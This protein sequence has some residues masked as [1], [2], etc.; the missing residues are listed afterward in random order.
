MGRILMNI[1]KLSDRGVFAFL[2]LYGLLIRL[3]FF[4]RDYVDRDE[5]SFIIMGQSVVDGHLPYTQLWDI[6]PPVIFFFFALIIYVFGKSFIAIR[7][8]GVALVAITAFFTY[9]LTNINNAKRIALCFGALCVILQSLF[10]SLQ[11]VMSEHIAMAFFT[12]AIYFMAKTKTKASTWLLCGVLVGLGLMV[13]L[14]LAYVALFL[15]CTILTLDFI[16]IRS[17]KSLSSSMLFGI[18]VLIVIVACFLPY[19][20]TDNSS[21][22]WKSVVEAPLAYAGARQYSPFKLLMYLM[23]CLLLFW[24]GFKKGIFQFK[25]RATV[26]LLAAT[27]GT[28]LAFIK[29]GRVNGHYL[30]LIYPVI[31]PL[32]ATTFSKAS[33]IRFKYST[34]MIIALLALIPMES[35]LEYYAIFKNKT[36]KNTFYNGEGITVPAYFEHNQL[37]TNN[38]YF[39]EYHIGYWMMGIQP[40]TKAATQPSNVLKDEMFFAYDNPRKTGEEELK[41]ILE[42]IKPQYIVTRKNRRVFDEK[43]KAVNFY[44]NLQLLTSYTPLD[45]ID[46]AII[47]KRQHLEVQ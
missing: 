1:E 33:A 26:F 6:K 45:T 13:K 11:G 5:S 30:I 18:G 44:I 22:W 39:A 20:L 36:E 35:Y 42:V 14:N 12:P 9:K 16:K 34:T 10:G 23:P 37:S 29:S 2:F 28:I 32:V 19:Y 21:L 8:I 4:F 7:L 46:N 47:H 43:K 15:G 25:N 40:I 3:P 38:V 31:L 24:I 41:H 27:L 17:I